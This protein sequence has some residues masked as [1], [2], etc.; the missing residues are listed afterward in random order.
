MK[1]IIILII[2]IIPFIVSA[3]EESA[4]VVSIVPRC[5]YV[6][7]KEIIGMVI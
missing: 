3:K 5:V 4:K 1:K 2:L 7:D 6:T